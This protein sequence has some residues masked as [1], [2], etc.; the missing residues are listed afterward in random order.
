VR[1]FAFFLALFVVPVL[2][3]GCVGA[4]ARRA[5]AL[6][7]QAEQ[8]QRDVR[9]EGFVVR[10]TTDAEGRSAGVAMQGGAVL[11]GAGAGDFY[12][13]ASGTGQLESNAL[14]F[15]VMR[16]AG[17]VTVREQGRTETLPVAAAQT[18]LGSEVGDFTKSLDVA[19][20]V[21]SVSVGETELAGR[22]A[23]RIV[24]KLDTKALLNGIG[25][26]GSQSLGALGV[27]FGGIRAVLYI[28]RDTHLVEVMFADLDV[29]VAGH[30]A[31]LHVSVALNDVDQPVD[32]PTL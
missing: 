11:K 12:L 21:T 25:G 6:L 2:A 1:R 7:Q 9:S 3:A 24:G 22:P 5:E 13:T 20:Y 26:M 18:R 27:D 29:K 15:A 23:D 17:T 16:R 8:A 30:K 4:D 14:S 10:F 28:P 31:H 19:Q 32:F